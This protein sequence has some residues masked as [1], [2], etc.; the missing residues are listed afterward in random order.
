[1]LGEHRQ[2]D[3]H[4]V[5]GVGQVLAQRALAIVAGR[6]L[7]A[8]LGR[9]RDERVA[10]LAHLVGAA[11]GGRVDEAARRRAAHVGGQAPDAPDHRPHRHQHRDQRRRQRRQP[12][13]G[14]RQDRADEAAR[15]RAAHQHVGARAVGPRRSHQHLDAI[16][17]GRAIDRR[18]RALGQRRRGGAIDARRG[19]IAR[20]QGAIVGEEPRRRGPRQA[21]RRAARA[22]RR[23]PRPRATAGA[24]LGAG[25]ARRP[26]RQRIGLA[27]RLR[28]G[29]LEPLAG[30]PRQ[31]LLGRAVPAARVEPHQPGDQRHRDRHGRQQEAQ[32]Q[33][34]AGALPARR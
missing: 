10:E 16:V 4:V 31:R 32:P 24:M 8:D 25:R 34:H 20:G 6:E 33:V 23:R 22:V 12:Q 15:R 13:L 11:H 19:R 1:V 21:G 14:G 28:L 7:A 3:H 2:R 9:R 27:P 30:E 29:P 26:P 5:G 18:P 17:E